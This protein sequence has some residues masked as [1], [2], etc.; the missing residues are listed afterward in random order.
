M[1]ERTMVGQPAGLRRAA[2]SR[3][4]GRSLALGGLLVGLVLPLLL[5]VPM[6]YYQMT[7]MLYPWVG[8][9]A[10][11][12]VGLVLSGLGWRRAGA[13]RWARSLALAGL[14][15]S[16]LMTGL[17][18]AGWIGMILSMLAPMPMTPMG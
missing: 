3:A 18:L 7:F 2:I 16:L 8:P 9:T 10:C 14:A 6:F 12:V 13:D 17:A 5:L 11:G 15:T 4:G 1:S